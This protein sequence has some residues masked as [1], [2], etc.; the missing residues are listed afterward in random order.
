VIVDAARSAL[1][2]PKFKHLKQFHEL[3]NPYGKSMWK[4][5]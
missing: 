4:N 1:S 3:S 2:T 5:E